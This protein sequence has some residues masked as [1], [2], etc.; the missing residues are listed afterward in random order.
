MTDRRRQL[1]LAAGLLGGA[2]VIG[3]AAGAVSY[4]SSSLVIGPAWRADTAELRERGASIYFESC[5]QFA[6]PRFWP[7][8]VGDAHAKRA[9]GAR[10]LVAFCTGEVR[11]NRFLH[12]D[13]CLSDERPPIALVGGPRPEDVQVGATAAGLAFVALGVL[14][15]WRRRRPAG[16]D[17]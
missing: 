5:A 9:R 11:Y 17:G 8:C 3:L 14:A 12:A 2:L 10:E 16:A 13:D 4:L 7:E 1:R 15:A 6:E